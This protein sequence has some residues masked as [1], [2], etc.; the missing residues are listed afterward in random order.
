MAASAT[1]LV[2]AFTK[3]CR[4]ACRARRRPGRRSGTSTLAPDGRPRR[5]SAAAATLVAVAF[6]CPP[7]SAGWLRRR[8]H[9]LAWTVSLAMFAAGL[10]RAVVGRGRGWDDVGL[11][12]LLPVR[13]H[14]QRALAGSRH[15]R[16][17]SAARRAGRP[18]AA[19]S[20]PSS[21][22]FAAGVLMVAPLRR[23][24]CRRPTASPRAASCSG[25][26]PA[27]S[28]RSA[29][30]CGAVVVIGGALRV[31]VAAAAGPAALGRR[32]AAGRRRPGRLA[33]RQRPHRRWARSSCR[34]A[35]R[36]RRGSA[37]WTA[38]AVTLVV[39]VAVLFAGLPGGHAGQRRP[40]RTGRARCQRRPA[41]AG[42]APADR[43]HRSAQDAAQDLAAD[44]PG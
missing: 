24:P 35:A 32:P 28:P 36:W 17:C 30:G 8:P 37:S 3:R 4:S 9:E 41:D 31:G 19:R 20:S 44:A 21:S 39:G 11:P 13:R 15:R 25:R 14:P 33:A 10:R 6:A 29:R 5:R 22:A 23:P 12:G 26:S 2:H 18:R 40:C 16:T 27:C 38:F 7:S 43:R 1:P 42:L 34:P